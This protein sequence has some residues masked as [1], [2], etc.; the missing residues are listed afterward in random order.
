MILTIIKSLIESADDTSISEAESSFGEQWD[1]FLHLANQ[2][3]TGTLPNI[4]ITDATKT[5][6]GTAVA[7]A[8]KK[9]QTIYNRKDVLRQKKQQQIVAILLTELLPSVF[10]IFSDI[11]NREIETAIK[12]Q[13][14]E[15][16]YKACKATI[17]NENLDKHF[18]SLTAPEDLFSD[19]FSGK[20][21]TLSDA[22]VNDILD[23][24][25]AARIE[26]FG[27]EARD[28]EKLK[29][30]L[31][32]GEAL[33]DAVIYDIVRLTILSGAGMIAAQN[34]T[35]ASDVGNKESIERVRRKFYYEFSKILKRYVPSESLSF[36]L[37]RQD[38]LTKVLSYHIKKNDEN[39]PE[40]LDVRT[41]VTNILLKEDAL[42][43]Y[44]IIADSILNNI[45]HIPQLVSLYYT[46]ALADPALMSYDNFYSLN[47][48]SYKL[49]L[50]LIDPKYSNVISASSTKQALGQGEVG[51]NRLTTDD[52]TQSGPVLDKYAETEKTDYKDIELLDEMDEVLSQTVAQLLMNNVNFYAIIARYIEILNKNKTDIGTIN[53]K[54]VPISGTLYEILNTITLSYKQGA[55]DK[56]QAYKQ[57]QLRLREESFQK[58]SPE[59]AEL[60]SECFTAVP[61]GLEAF[62]TAFLAT[63]RSN[64]IPESAFYEPRQIATARQRLRRQAISAQISGAMY[65]YSLLFDTNNANILSQFT[66]EEREQL[67]K[68]AAANDLTSFFILLTTILLEPNRDSKAA[69]QALGKN[70]NSKEVPV[71]VQVLKARNKPKVTGFINACNT[72]GFEMTPQKL[73]QTIAPDL[74]NIVELVNTAMSYVEANRKQFYTSRIVNSIHALNTLELTT[75]ITE[76]VEID[77]TEPEITETPHQATTTILPAI[78]TLYTMSVAALHDLSLFTSYVIF[79][80]MNTPGSSMHKMLLKGTISKQNIIIDPLIDSYLNKIKADSE[81][82]DILESYRTQLQRAARAGKRDAVRILIKELAYALDE[83]YTVSSILQTSKQATQKRVVTSFTPDALQAAGGIE[84]DL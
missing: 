47:D 15:I 83:P 79:K 32:S 6:A 76:D 68:L 21:P 29:H 56:Y 3:Q 55:E 46:T 70:I 26:A 41:I 33:K 66:D 17:F 44:P 19:A 54:K 27:P 75:S 24:I 23:R 35:A 53:F 49:L 42:T 43:I 18:F 2:V 11:E 14:E 65:F 69:F 50:K 4:N 67:H 5:E 64:G 45:K 34:L 60:L 57:S 84:L 40:G 39:L 9:M 28:P 78:N 10:G 63:T 51:E 31:L 81:N 80:V 7:T 13:P 62:S 37:A 36:I 82:S 52:D 20:I 22:Y 30:K 72:V 8:F 16:L 25:A 48:I 61:K 77:D 71:F 74:G 12:S 73:V 1:Q 38:E 59:A 58:L